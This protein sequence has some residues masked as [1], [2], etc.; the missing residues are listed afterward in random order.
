MIRIMSDGQ[1]LGPIQNQELSQYRESGMVLPGHEDMLAVISKYL[2]AIRSDT[3]NFNKRQ[4]AFMDCMLTVTQPTPLRRARQ[5]LSEIERSMIALRETYYKHKKEEIKIEKLEYKIKK[6]QNEGQFGEDNL[7]IKMFQVKIEEKRAALQ[8]GKGYV[9][10]AIRKITQLIE[11][12]NSILE[13]AGV[14]EFT[15]EAFEKEEEE[16]H[17]KTALLQ[18]ISAA[19][20][21]GGI[22]D[23]GNHIYLQQLGINGAAIQRDLNELFKQEQQLIQEGKA[24]GFDMVMIWLQ[25]AYEGYK[26]CSEGY[27]KFKGMDGTYRPIALIDQA[28]KLIQQAS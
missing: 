22:I 3:L 28:K 24:P 26:G 4:S 8:H 11:Q 2:P 17:I 23:E 18:A 25:K 14:K 6:I 20:S 5:C 12:Y 19:R 9:S 21:R 27:A 1:D 16:Y 7:E 15:E 10:G 13:K